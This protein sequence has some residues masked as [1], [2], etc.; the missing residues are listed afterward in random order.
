[1]LLREGLA[2][3]LEDAGHEVVARLGDAASL[4]AVAYLRS[5]AA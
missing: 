5:S 1:V 4:L 2:G 3:L